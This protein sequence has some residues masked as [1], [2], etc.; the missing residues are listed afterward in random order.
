MYEEA[1]SSVSINGHISGPIPIRCGIRQGCPLS[2]ILFAMCIQ[3]L[4]QMLD[5]NLSVVQLQRTRHRTAVIAYA[6]DVTVFVTKPEEFRIIRDTARWFEKA[7]GAHLN[8]MKTKAIAIGGWETPGNHLGVEYHQTVKILGIHF[9]STMEQIM[10]GN[11]TLQTA[12]I[13]TN[14]KQAYIRELYLAQRIRYVHSTLLATIW[15]TAQILPAPVKYTTQIMTAILWFIWKGAIF[16]YRLSRCRN[17][18]IK[19]YGPD[20]T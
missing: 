9:R 4:L 1:Y 8:I 11:W 17:Q 15:L 10:Q 3:P 20:K 13:K 7:S 5:R 6:D 19:E 18:S 14:A 12:R 16:V 2:M